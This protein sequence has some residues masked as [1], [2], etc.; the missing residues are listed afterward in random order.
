M[1]TLEVILDPEM[2]RKG[3]LGPLDAEL[4]FT[5][6][7][8]FYLLC[9]IETKSSGLYLHHYGALLEEITYA[10]PLDVVA[11]LKNI[12]LDVAKKVLDRV[13]FY[14]EEKEKRLLENESLS[15][16]N[17]KRRLEIIDA[18]RELR[19]HLV[20]DGIKPDD[21]AK[22]LGGLLSHQQAK[23]LLSGPNSKSGKKK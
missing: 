17:A 3:E 7:D 12:P 22:M 23:F 4:A 6:I 20:S 14:S 5:L 2:Q 11:Y 1:A 21:A 16:D 10:S 19:N 8:I 13:L 18:A 9:A 15:L